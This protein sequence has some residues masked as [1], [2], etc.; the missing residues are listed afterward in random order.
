M[1]IKTIGDL[2]RKT[3]NELLSCENFGRKTLTDI[4][5]LLAR[6]GLMLSTETKTVTLESLLKS[7][8]STEEPQKSDDVLNKPIFE[9]D[10]SARVRGSLTRLKVYTVGDLVNKSE[11]DFMDLPN[12]GQTSL[13]EIKRRLSQTGLVLKQTE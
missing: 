12:F 5:E 8:I 1:D 13:D 7:Y 11:K 2:V 10:W 6:R 9:I 3:E 4:K